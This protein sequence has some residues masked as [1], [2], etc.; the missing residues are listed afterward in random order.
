MMSENQDLINN[1]VQE[2]LRAL[3]CQQQMI[4]AFFYAAIETHPAPDQLKQC[5][6]ESS[7]R[8]IATSIDKPLPDDWLRQSIGYRDMLVLLID[9]KIAQGS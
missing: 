7:E 4:T 3:E 9:N 6:V 8:L 1:N 5:F 2:R